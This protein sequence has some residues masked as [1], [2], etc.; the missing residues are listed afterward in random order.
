MGMK[1]T[2]LSLRACLVS[3]MV[4]GGV[5]APQA[6]AVTEEPNMTLQSCVL[7]VDRTGKDAPPIIGAPIRMTG[8]V[9]SEYPDKAVVGKPATIR[10]SYPPLQQ[11]KSAFQ[12][13]KALNVPNNEVVQ[14]SFRNFQLEGGSDDVRIVMAADHVVDL[15][16]STVIGSKNQYL[17][18]LGTGF[19]FDATPSRAGKIPVALAVQLEKPPFRMYTSL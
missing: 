14:L 4:F 3:V 15:G 11:L 8:Y 19:S 16:E 5:M 9:T 7:T 17:F 1:V 2:R 13:T 18:S 12:A 10:V 6:A